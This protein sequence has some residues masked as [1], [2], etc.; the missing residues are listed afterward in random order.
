VTT[1]PDPD[2]AEFGTEENLEGHLQVMLDARDQVDQ[3][4]TQLEDA[5]KSKAIA[6]Q[7]VIGKMLEQGLESF[8]ALGKSITLSEK[9]CP[10]VL[11]EDRPLQFDW[12]R[13]IGAGAMIQETVNAQSFAGLVRNDFVK[14]KREAEL[15]AFIKIH[16]E[17]NLLVR[18][19][20]A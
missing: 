5:K 15:P 14:A 17:P 3:L 8:R 11:K 12:L 19:V 18:S 10:S 6:E 7:A 20:P 13:E 9:I 1:G 2:L 16:K 4:E